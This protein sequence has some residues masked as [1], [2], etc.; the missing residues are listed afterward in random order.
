MLIQF[1]VKNYLSFRDEVSLSL[2]ATK[3]TE[4]HSHIVEV[5]NDKVLKVAVIYGA[6]AS[7]KSNLY[8]AYRFMERYVM[9][10]FGFGGEEIDGKNNKTLKAEATEKVLPLKNKIKV[11]LKEISSRTS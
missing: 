2:E 10:S 9:E 4:H 6:N 11:N 1:N 5:S 3:M 8:D 7:G